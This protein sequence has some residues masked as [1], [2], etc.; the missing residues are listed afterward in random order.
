LA[1]GVSRSGYVEIRLDRR[2]YRA[3]RL[4]WLHVH[5]A[6]PVHEID[7]INGEKADNRIAN[8]R[9]ATSGQN[10]A[11]QTRLRAD[12]TSGH[13]GVSWSKANRKWFAKIKHAGRQKL[14]GYFDSKEAAVEA[15]ELAAASRFGEFYSP[16]NQATSV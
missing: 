12:N 15:Y 13:R 8:L 7:H 11:N 1:G 9:D 14:L 5:G 16:Q 4:A 10:K 2:L 3:H 6:W